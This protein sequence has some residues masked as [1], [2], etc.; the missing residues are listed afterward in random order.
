MSN[1]TL[2]H[3][4]PEA[5]ALIV[6]MARVSNPENADNVETAPRLLRYLIKHEHWSPFEMCSMA[7]NIS[8]ERDIS[9]QITRHRSFS[10][11]EF[12]TRYSQVCPPA[13]PAMRMQAQT[14]RQSSTDLPPE[15]VAA[16]F[17]RRIDSTLHNVYI[18]YN[19]LLAAG[20]AREC[21]RRI[22]PLCAPT[23]LYMQGTLRSWIHYIKLRT[24]PDTQLEHREVAEAC[25]SI[26]CQQFPIVADAAFS[27]TAPA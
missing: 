3:A 6:R 14:N 15:D 9:A 1:V 21:A 12:S 25:K 23:T 4:T 20:I 18:L 10:F 7:V 26:F 16:D 22:L 24:K 13:L 11:Q 27:V 2:I 5:E 17:N 19:E 8:T